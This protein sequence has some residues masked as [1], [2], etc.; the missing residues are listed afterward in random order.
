MNRSRPGGEPLRGAAF[1]DSALAALGLRRGERARFRRPGA[2]RWERVLIEGTERDG[3]LRLRDAK[4][5]SRAI[6][7]EHVE[8]STVGRRGVSRWE[9]VADR[10]ARTE[11]LRLL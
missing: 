9:P 1:E 7:V 5:A 11:Q 10:A 6:R 2:R 4:G 8:V 3:S